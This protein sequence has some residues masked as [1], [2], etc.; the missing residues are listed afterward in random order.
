M[1]LGLQ[2]GDEEVVA[3]LRS[4]GL[5]PVRWVGNGGGVWGG[6]GG[7]DWDRTGGTPVLL[8]ELD[9]GF[10]FAGGA[11]GELGVGAV[12]LALKGIAREG[13]EVAGVV[14]VKSGPIDS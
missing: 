12:A 3:R 5:W 14:V 9:P 2:L 6:I 11:F 1:E 13:E 4:T 8:R 10:A 7:V